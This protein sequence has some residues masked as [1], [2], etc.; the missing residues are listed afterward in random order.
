M[1]GDSVDHR[2]AATV[3][4]GDI[5]KRKTFRDRGDN[6]YA[7]NF[8]FY[9]TNANSVSTRQSVAAPLQ[10]ASYSLDTT[11]TWKS[12]VIIQT[13]ASKALTI[14]APTTL[15]DD[16]NELLIVNNNAGSNTVTAG[17][18]KIY[19]DGNSTTS[20]AARTTVTLH[21]VGAFIKLVA[22]GGLWFT[23]AATLDRDNTDAIY[24][25][26]A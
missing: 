17:A 26:Y 13:G 2:G 8:Y 24:I 12:G 5:R 18:N 4:P 20:P 7:D 6:D 11:T 19:D 9:S 3:V 16:G 15:T 21:G 25:T 22:S 1:S 14:P 10:K 23:E